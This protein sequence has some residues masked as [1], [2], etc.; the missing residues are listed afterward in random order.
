V[1]SSPSARFA[2]LFLLSEGIVRKIG[3]VLA[4]LLLVAGAG[5][6]E[7]F[8]TFLEQI[9]G[10]NGVAYYDVH[11]FG[12]NSPLYKKAKKLSETEG[13][14]NTDILFALL[15]ISASNLGEMSPKRSTQSE[16]NVI[17]WIV[18]HE[19]LENADVA[20]VMKFNG[21]FV[22]YMAANSFSVLVYNPKRNG[23]YC[24]RVEP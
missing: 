11:E 9:D 2:W 21:D 12:E 14:T 8:H 10:F 23:L 18:K 19:G 5:F 22:P 16:R 15:V 7:E 17:N 1:L 3:V 24:C 4:V 20:I 13:A 6:G